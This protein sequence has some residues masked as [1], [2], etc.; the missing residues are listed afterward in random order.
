VISPRPKR[1][2]EITHHFQE[3]DAKLVAVLLTA[4]CGKLPAQKRGGIIGAD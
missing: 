3:E 1:I 2:Q 4:D